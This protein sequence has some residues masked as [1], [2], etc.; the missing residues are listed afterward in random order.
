MKNKVRPFQSLKKIKEKYIKTVQEKLSEFKI[1]TLKLNLPK[2]YW[3]HPSKS[4]L[5][6][7]GAS[8]QRKTPKNKKKNTNI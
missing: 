6:Q 1:I 2:G 7:F 4:F 8:C 5:Q 3:K